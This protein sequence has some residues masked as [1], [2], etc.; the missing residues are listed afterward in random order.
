MYTL[1]KFGIIIVANKCPTFFKVL[2][3]IVDRLVARF[4][5]QGLG[6]FEITIE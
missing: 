1:K 2:S 4:L 5:D 6:V 3:L